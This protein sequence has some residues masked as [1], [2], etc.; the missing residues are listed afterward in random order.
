MN[1]K[2]TGKTSQRKPTFYYGWIMIAVGFVNLGIA[3]GVWYSFSVFIL[4][5]IKEFGWSRAA[6]SSI[7]SVFIFSQALMNLLSGHLQD[8]F[9]PRVVIPMGA[10]LLSLSLVLTSQSKML[11][12]FCLTYGV[13]AGA[14]ISLLGF[15]SHAAFIPKWFERK[16]GLAV[17]IAMSGIGFGMFFLIPLVEKSISLY[18]WRMTY[19]FLAALVLFL[20][21]PMNIIFSRR[22][23]EAIGQMPDGDDS[24]GTKKTKHSMSVKIVN[25]SWTQESWTLKKA[26]RTKRFWYLAFA[27]YFIAFTYQGTLLH[28]VSAMVDFGLKRENAAYFFGILGVMGSVG[29]IVLGYLSDLYSRERVNTLGAILAVVGILS[30]IHINNA[31]GIFPFLFAIFFGLG[32]GAAAPLLPSVCADIFIG[33]SFGLIFAMIAIGGGAGGATGS[34]MAGLLRDLSGTYF[35]PFIVFIF[36]LLASCILIWLASP[37][38][39]RI[40]VKTSQ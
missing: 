27:F 19:L 22:S 31:P 32:Y 34:Y 36:T 1:T 40:M 30:L 11:W 38:K 13:L 14:G 20:I 28:S 8:R 21:T 33:K 35:V 4:S 26:I 39:I 17:G 16:R 15:A 3:F 25:E 6:A 18:G 37:S 2:E 10:V 24:K 29:K 9:G 23:P 12:H 7:F 5:I